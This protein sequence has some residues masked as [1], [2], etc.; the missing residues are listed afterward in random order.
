MQDDFIE[1]KEFIQ[2]TLHTEEK[3]QPSDEPCGIIYCRK[4]D[5]CESVS[6]GL[7][8]QGVSCSPFHSGMKK[9]DKEQA[10]NDWMS[11]KIQIIVGN[12]FLFI[13]FNTIFNTDF[14]LFK[15]L[16]LLAW[17]LIN[18]QLGLLFIG[19]SVKMFLHTIRF[20]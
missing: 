12:K 4:K 17:A 18:F 13:Y 2:K 9:S 20:E 14:N 7:R 10:Q 15:L 16:L 1:L 3:L 11:G 8:K 19:M 5:T 6:Q